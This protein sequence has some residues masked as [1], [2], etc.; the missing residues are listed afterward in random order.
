MGAALGVLDTH[1]GRPLTAY[2]LPYVVEVVLQLMVALRACPVEADDGALV[3]RAEPLLRV[4][5]Y[6][7]HLVVR[8]V[9]RAS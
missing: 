5:A 1:W 7:S 4:W 3:L 9:H 2:P 8:H 6:R